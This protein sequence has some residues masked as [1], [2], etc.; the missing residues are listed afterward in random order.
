MKKETIEKNNGILAKFMNVQVRTTETAIT[1]YRPDKYWEV[2]MPVVKKVREILYNKNTKVSWNLGNQ[3][4]LVANYM[5]LMKSF[6]E[7][8]VFRTYKAVVKC[9]KSINR[10]TS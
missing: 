7:V 5:D 2:L 8:D 4:S 1:S 3:I 9:V 6:Y 10:H